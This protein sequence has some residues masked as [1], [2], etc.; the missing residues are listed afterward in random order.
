MSAEHFR[1]QMTHELSTCVSN[2]ATEATETAYAAR[3]HSDPHRPAPANS[4]LQSGDVTD[5]DF[6][7][8]VAEC[9]RCWLSLSY[10]SSSGIGRASVAP[11]LPRIDRGSRNVDS[12]R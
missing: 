4:E 1:A 9:D 7:T 6:Y 10:S 11:R 2:A 8:D 5:A 3:H 12:P